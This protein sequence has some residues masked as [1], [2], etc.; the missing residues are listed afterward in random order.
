MKKVLSL[1][2]LIACV[3]TNAQEKVL[4]VSDKDSTKIRAIA[5]QVHLDVLPYYNFGKGIGITSPDSLFQLNLRFRMQNRLEAR[6]E[7]HEPVQFQGAIRRLRLRFDGYV[8]NPK[9]LYAIQLSFAPE[10]VG[11]AKDGQYINIIRDAVVFYRANEHWTFGFGQTKLPGNRQRNNSSGAL[12]LTDRSI[13]NAM[14]NID[15][16]FGFQAIYSHLKENEFGYNLKGV[17]S[18]GG[19]RNFNEPT[20]GLAYTGRVELYPLGKF[21]KKG[22]FFEG[23]LMRETSPKLYLGG[24]YHFNQN[25]I[26]A[27]GQR[28][29]TLFEQRNLNAL[30][31]DAMLKYNGWS[32]M[33]AFMNRTT[34]D[35][36]TYN[37]D[38]SKSQYVLAGY[39][40]DG[41]LSYTFPSHWEIIGRYSHNE[42]NKEIQQWQPI[43][44]QFSLGLTKYI[45]EH[46]FKVQFEV[47][48]NN[49]EFLNGEKKDNWYARFQVEIGI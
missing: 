43:H 12:D 41:Q 26:K 9:F 24:T 19:G 11:R 38:R 32:A 42:P 2:T 10:D 8:G 4:V 36:I 31:L 16:D 5:K 7:D 49:F 44:N 17:I 21:K 15:R 30:L 40:Y 48:K 22:E 47:N 6:F 35:P 20:D 13:N 29:K 14:F 33:A 37:A 39:G 1:L 28:G 25:A 3:W 34:Q 46:A 45:W 18:T 23:D 27:Q